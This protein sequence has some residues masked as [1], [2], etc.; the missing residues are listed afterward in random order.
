[1]ISWPLPANHENEAAE[2]TRMPKSIPYPESLAIRLGDCASSLSAA[3]A[4][5]LLRRATAAFLN[6]DMVCIRI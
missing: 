6:L 5:S 2:A 4:R 3:L 1:M